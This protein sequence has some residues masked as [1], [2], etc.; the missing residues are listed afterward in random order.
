MPF[1]AKVNFKL[2]SLEG[3][4]WQPLQN[5]LHGILGEGGGSNFPIN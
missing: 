3:V 5:Q 2:H 1:Q 4:H